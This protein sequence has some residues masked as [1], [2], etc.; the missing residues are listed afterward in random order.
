MSAGDKIIINDLIKIMTRT[1]F[2]WTHTKFENK[3]LMWT[4]SPGEFDF[5]SE[6]P[7]ECKTHNIC[8]QLNLV[9]IA[10]ENTQ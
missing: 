9:G 4:Q 10:F 8:R 7:C 5:R 2:W 1:M 3:Y 6:P